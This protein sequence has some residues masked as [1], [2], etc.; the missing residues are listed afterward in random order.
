MTE[1]HRMSYS[2]PIQ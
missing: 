2:R 1:R